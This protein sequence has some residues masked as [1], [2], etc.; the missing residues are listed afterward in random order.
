MLNYPAIVAKLNLRQK[1]ALL[2]DLK[3][4]SNGE[5]DRAGIPAVVLASL[6]EINA[7]IDAARRE[8]SR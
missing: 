4:L 6:E 2:T 1:L 5:I 8:G 3:S 7:E